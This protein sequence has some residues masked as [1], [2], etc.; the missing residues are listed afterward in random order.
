MKIKYAISLIIYYFLTNVYL[1]GQCPP[2][3]ITFSSQSEIDNFILNYPN[4]E[5]LEFTNISGNDISNLNGF[6]N[7]KYMCDDLRITNCPNLIDI[8]GLSNITYFFF[9]LYQWL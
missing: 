9:S 7:I 3:N 4:C 2:S 5:I 1:F 6:S 8:S